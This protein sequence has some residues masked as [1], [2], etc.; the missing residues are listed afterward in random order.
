MNPETDRYDQL[1]EAIEFEREEEHNY[2]Q[3]LSKDKSIKEK[4]EAGILWYPLEIIKQHY[5]VGE[6]IEVIFEKTKNLNLPHKLKSGAG[7]LLFARQGEEKS[8]EI[9]GVISW[10][11]RNRLSLILNESVLSKD[12]LSDLKGQ[13]G[14]ELVHDERP[15]KIMKDAIKKIKKTDK[16]HLKELREGIKKLNGLDYSISSEYTYVPQHLNPS[17]AHALKEGLSAQQIAIIHGPPGT[18]KT[19]TIVALIIELV[20]QE[21][22]VLVCAPSNNAVDLLATKIDQ[23]G[24]PT[25]RVGNV[26]RIADNLTH[27]T[28]AEKAR[29][30]Q[31]WKHIKKVRIEAEVAKK[32]ASKFKRSFGAKERSNRNMM[33]KESRELRKWA[34][35]LEDKLLDKLVSEAKVICS[36][37]IGVSHKTIEDLQFNSLVIDE[38]SQALEPECWNAMLRAKRVFLTGDHLQLAPVVKSKK[39]EELGLAQTLLG[40]LSDKIKHSYL[41]DTQYRMN[42]KILSFSNK[43]FYDNK[44][45]SAI[46]VADWTLDGDMS[47]LVLVDTSGCGFDENFNK[48][49]RSRYNE[50]EF[51]IFREHFIQN[52]EKYID[53]SI[54]VISPYS[55]Q[56]KFL[57]SKVDTEEEFKP[58]DI[59]VNT[60]DGFQG[61]ERDVIYISLVRSNTEGEIGFLKDE[62]RLNVAMTRARKKL[63]II[64]DL[65]T[66][67]NYK[68]FDQMAQHIET[69]G[70]YVSAWEYMT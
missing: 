61:Q 31:E 29:D 30:H 13:I 53:A 38:A 28:I 6:Q 49:S 7:C 36:T 20:K 57:N 67:S 2:Y 44:L 35:D 14:I 5:S 52:S 32:Q 4:I 48:K 11:K 42:E 43:M 23:A 27:L 58:F 15:Y 65:S 22:R 64:G 66:L 40:R 41:L 21:K 63:V 69:V 19:T 62:K 8:I 56:I 24:I 25:L 33:Y 10:I 1:L 26:T 3:S 12:Q 34:R 60:I 50:G 17:Q 45:K 51:F 68:L 16:P 9:K 37:L 54:G 46:G 70:T 18:G 47:P 39:A 55:E 59:K